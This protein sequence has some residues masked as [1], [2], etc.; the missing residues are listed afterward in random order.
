MLTGIAVKLLRKVLNN[1]NKLF[2]IDLPHREAKD[3]TVT[4][5]LEDLSVIWMD[6]KNGAVAQDLA[7]LKSDK[8]TNVKTGSLDR[9]AQPAPYEWCESDG[10]YNYL[11][12]Q[13]NA[14][15]NVY[16]DHAFKAFSLFGAVYL[17]QRALW[18][19]LMDYSSKYIEKPPKDNSNSHNIMISCVSFLIN[20]G[21][22]ID[23]EIKAGDTAAYYLMSFHAKQSELKP[24]GFYVPL[25]AAF[26]ITE[27]E[28]EGALQNIAKMELYKSRHSGG[29]DE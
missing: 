19:Y 1:G 5:T 29:T 9:P 16:E 10:F 17:T 7:S 25:K 18:E 20:K 6:N 14:D 8:M 26:F 2:S 11:I 28:K 23:S 22:A 3:G 13:V 12:E 27:R 4:I 15:V 21:L 24:K